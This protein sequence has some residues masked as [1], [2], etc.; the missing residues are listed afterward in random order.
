M[1]NNSGAYGKFVEKPHNET[2]EN[3]IN[4]YGI[5]DS[6]VSKNQDMKLSAK[7]TYIPLATIPAWGR[8]SLITTAL[9]FG[10]ENVIYFDTDSI[11]CVYNEHT[12]KVWET[13]NQK[14]EL[15]GWGLEEIS[16]RSQFS[17][18]K[19]YKLQFEK[20][21]GKKE[22]VIKSGGINFDYYKETTHSEELKKL[23]E[24]GYLKRDALRMIDVSF[25]EIN[26]ISSKWMVQ[27]AYRVKGGTLIEFQ[28][29]K[30]DVQQKYIEIYEK[31]INN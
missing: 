27:R 13:I 3:Y 17:A 23:L 18:S 16:E 5:I 7:Y 12:K 22:V 24:Q 9:K 4:E 29:K 2:F 1:L 30:M 21:N 10:W 8:V 28:E 31:N 20:P 6:K 14:D 26:I 19:R 25:D 15:G 11:F